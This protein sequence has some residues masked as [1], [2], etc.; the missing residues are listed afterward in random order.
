MRP[1]QRHGA[2]RGSVRFRPRNAALGGLILINV[3]TDRNCGPKHKTQNTGESKCERQDTCCWQCWVAVVP[4][5]DGLD[6][7]LADA[8]TLGCPVLAI[9]QGPGPRF[10]FTTNPYG[11]GV[12]NHLILQFLVFQVM[13]SPR[14]FSQSTRLDSISSPFE[15]HDRG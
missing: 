8:A 13:N 11:F 3:L 15:V 9:S 7:G 10:R 14:Q 12:R 2:V 5:F 1:R 6:F 4:R